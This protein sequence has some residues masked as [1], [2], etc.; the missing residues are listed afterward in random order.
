MIQMTEMRSKEPAKK[1]S[2][3]LKKKLND[4]SDFDL[5]NY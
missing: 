2:V 4:S 1:A 5:D 3:T